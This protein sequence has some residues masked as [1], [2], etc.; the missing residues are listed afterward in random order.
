[1]RAFTRRAAFLLPAVTLGLLVGSSSALFAQGTPFV[2]YFGK[3]RVHYDNFKWHIYTTDHFEIYYYPELEQ[4][5]E[6]VASY[7][8]SAYQ[9]VSTELKHEL[10]FKVPLV[11]FKTQSEFQQQNVQPGELPEG[12]AAF[13][14]PQRDRMVLPIDEPSDQLYHLITHELTHVF[15]FDII[16]RSLV[17]RGFPLWVDEGMADYMT[18]SWE[19]IDLMTVRDVAVADIVP[20]MTEFEDY[21]GFSNPRIV[22]NLGHA[23]F[24]FMESKWGK[25]G[26]RQYV[27]SL[28]KSVIGG[29]NS[30]FEEAFR[31][32]PDEFDQQ[33]EKYLKDRFKPFRDKERPLDYGRDLSPDAKKTEY[34]A[35]ITVEPAPSGDLL[36][37][38]VGN[39]HDGEYDVVLISTKDGT[40]IRNLTPGFDKNRGFE[41]IAVPGLRWN[42]VPW[43]SWSPVGDRVAY[44]VRTE[45]QRSLIVQNVV[46]GATETRIEMKTVDVPE[47]PAF[48]RD[49]KKITFS[50]LQ[51]G[52]GDLYTVDLDTKQLTNITKDD[53][54]DYAPTYSPDGKYLV[55]MARVSG[56][57]KLFRL[58][59][60]SGKKTQLTFGTH[61]DASARFLN[62]HTLVF[63]S[64]ATDP[65]KPI[66]PEEA[67]NGNIYNVW[68]LDMNTGELRQYT[69]A[70]TGNLCVI[71]LPDGPNSTKLAFVTYF[72][73]EFGVHTLTPKEPIATVASK[74]FGE[75]GPVIDFQPPL[76]HTLVKANEKKKGTFEKLFLDGRPPINVGVTSG[77]DLFGG[78]QIT[79]SDVLGDQQF[80]LYVA[81]ISQYRTLALSYINQGARFQY[82]IQ[83]FTQTDFFYSQTDQLF[84]Q[85]GYIP[86]I[87]RDQAIATRTVRGGSISGYYPFNRYARVEMSGGLVQYNEEYSDP[88]LQGI[89]E[90]YQRAQYGSVLF[91]NGTMVP[92]SVAF[93]SEDTIFREYG[94]LS[95]KTLRF[96]YDVSPKIGSTLSRQAVDLDGRWYQR[97]AGNG[98]AAFR[99]KGFRSWGEFPDFFYFG[100]NSE[101]RGYDYLSFIGNE[102][103][104]ANAELRFPLV[105]AMLTPIGVLGGIRGIFFAN[106]GTAHFYEQSQTPQGY[107][108]ATSK[109][110]VYKSLVAIDCSSPD[111]ISNQCNP[112]YKDVN[113][114]GFRLRDGR[115]SY[116]VGLESFILGFPIHFDFSWRTLF[117]KSW[118]DAVFALDGG[119]SKFRKAQ[120]N[121]WIG[122]DF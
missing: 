96:A 84:Y 41:Y 28:R 88:T 101:M 122:Y 45:K 67:R 43:L 68:S 61:D 7:A 112:I 103:F 31:I 86:Y 51:N 85:A 8:E 32:K 94:P 108:F 47:S 30:A 66:T 99:L 13:A 22:Y 58:D 62:D 26:V 107:K 53:F 4:H 80:N 60:E 89:S 29:G 82:G 78:S 64:T 121:V 118:E 120:F 10:G 93:V 115:A 39:R 20:K 52:V 72:K 16:P 77:G 21:G 24:E 11:L 92:F 79:F 105:E 33:F 111:P 40:V 56:N 110:E 55:Y 12:V 116:G 42:S 91:R 83:G 35:V 23:A 2:P 97:I 81:S 38:V 90:D 27:F 37:A 71:P 104:F 73:G 95:G 49:G 18:G 74:D 75:P 65:A 76:S 19:P 70:L 3:N 87:N 14:E 102:G 25:E 5:L 100:G 98:V 59:L 1:M 114:S 44:F 17:R 54:A 63:A 34:V 109:S 117:N 46:T 113:I 106:L 6:R 48:S 50:A 69:D 15:Q 57:N 36:A 119:S 9:H